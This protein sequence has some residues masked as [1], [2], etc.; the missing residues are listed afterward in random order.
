[1]ANIIPFP[2]KQ[3]VSVAARCAAMLDRVSADPLTASEQLNAFIG[4]LYED[5]TVDR[6]NRE[7]AETEKHRRR[8]GRNGRG[9]YT[10]RGKTE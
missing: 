6:W 3:P 1:M 4:E 8:I 5:G 9:T 7:K 10:S 2:V